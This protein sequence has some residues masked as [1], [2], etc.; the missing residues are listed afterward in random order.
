V[1]RSALFITIS[2]FLVGQMFAQGETTVSGTVTDAATG[3]A[4]VGANVVVEGTD[5]GDAADAN[6]NYSIVNVPAGATITASMIGYTG[7]NATAAAT[8]NF[9]LSSEAI[10]VEDIVVIGYGTQSRR[11]VTG[12][13]SSLKEGSFTKGATTDLQSLLQ[14]RVPGVVVTANNGDIGSEPR[15]RI[16]G[17]TSINASNNPIIVIDGVPIDNSSALPTGFTTGAGAGADGTRDNPLGMLN[18][19]DIAS[20]DILKDASSS[21]IYGA[22]G[23]NGVILITTK[24]GRPGEVSVSYNAYTS[25]SEVSKKLDLMSASEY[26]SYA[27]DIGA[28]IEDG[29]A[30]T[31]WQ[32]EIYRTALSQ[33]HYISFSAGTP[34]TQYRASLSYLNQQG[35]VINSE[36]ERYSA[37]LNV[38]HSMLDGKL[39]LG[40]RL[41]PSSQTRN[42]TPYNQQAGYFG[43]VFTNVLKFNPTY[44]V[45]NADGSYYEYAT[46]TIRNPVALLNEIAD[47]GENMR[48]LSS[49][50]AEYEIMSGLNAKVILGSDRESYTRSIYEPNSLPYA[51]ATGG[52][53]S[54]Q[55]NQRQ[56]ISFS[57]TLNYKT[58]NLELLAG[59]ASQE[60]TNSGFTA[61]SQSFVSDAW[62]YNNLGGAANF[63]TAPSSYKEQNSLASFFGRAVYRMGEKINFMATLRR[64]GSSRFGEDNK[65]GVF[66]SASVG[67]RA[68]DDIRVRASF[69]VTGNQEI[70][71][72]RSLV[73]LGPG[74]NAV[75]GGVLLT[76]VSANQLANPDLKW[77]NT[78]DMNLGVDF[79]LMDGKITGTVDM[80]SKTTE[81]MLVE[82]NVPQPAVVTTK[83]V[84]KTRGL[85][86]H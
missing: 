39:R 84:W 37:R 71:N 35:V 12:A 46:T 38:S 24:Q 79:V 20:I 62:L 60:F 53:A 11:D 33:S 64:E 47:V 49:A 15:I 25:T 9:A 26:K 1:N 68:T 14:A 7:A 76:G 61:V 32:D 57:S 77:E 42:N 13:I 69:G 51:A 63:T 29:G 43:G 8:V 4:L 5:L 59:Y 78:S 23:G 40:L 19:G 45:K 28:S 2:L 18:P 56:N 74:A 3:D 86:Y 83:L 73:T 72:Y 44:P 36:L 34:Q 54:V 16:R 22:R 66:P 6:G 30:N 17:G 70:G 85:N 10:A 52:N 82:V 41:N 65:W 21:A 75:I 81:D 27:S 48:V 80:Y 67:F 58:S 55:N 31:D 50:T